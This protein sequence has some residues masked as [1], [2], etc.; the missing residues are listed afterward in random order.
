[1]VDCSDGC[2]VSNA[3]SWRDAGNDNR[4]G[5]GGGGSEGASD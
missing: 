3:E 5:G 1:M 4:W 2:A